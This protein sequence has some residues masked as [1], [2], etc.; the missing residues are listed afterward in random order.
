MDRDPLH[1]SIAMGTNRASPARAPAPLQPCAGAQKFLCWCYPQ[2]LGPAPCS[3]LTA[4]R[5]LLLWGSTR[6]SRC[7][8]LP[9]LL[10]DGTETHAW[11]GQE[12]SLHLGKYRTTISQHSSQPSLTSS[13]RSLTACSISAPIPA[14][15]PQ[16]D[17]SPFIHLPSFNPYHLLT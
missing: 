2:L 16:A 10:R 5:F 15:A 1:H 11:K 12:G 4:W 3:H 6:P 8:S 9:F 17:S 7:C 13:V 14:A